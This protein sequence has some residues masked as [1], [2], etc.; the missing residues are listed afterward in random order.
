VA[1]ALR[2]DVCERAEE[3]VD[4]ELDFEDGHNRL[5]LVEVARRTVHGLGN[6]LKH[7]IQVDLVLLWLKRLATRNAQTRLPADTYPLAVV[8]EESLELDNVGMSD[9]AHDLEFA[10]LLGSAWLSLWGSHTR[11][12]P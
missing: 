1:D 9:N 7:E 12:A 4:V 5:H 10:V 11:N 8:V 6:E 3:L 2:V